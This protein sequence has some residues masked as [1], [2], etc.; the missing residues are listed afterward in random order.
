M[1]NL[2]TFFERL[3]EWEDKPAIRVAEWQF[4]E[5]D[6]INNDFQQAAALCGFD[7]PRIAFSDSN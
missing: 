7:A 6:E 3:A 4:A 1:W 2:Q 5:M